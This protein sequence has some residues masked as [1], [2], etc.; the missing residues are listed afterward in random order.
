MEEVGVVPAPVL[1][2]SGSGPLIEVVD[3]GDHIYVHDVRID[4]LKMDY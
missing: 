4:I 1:Y 3:N 2:P